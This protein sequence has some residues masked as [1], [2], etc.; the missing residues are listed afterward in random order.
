MLTF[1]SLILCLHYKKLSVRYRKR[2]TIS[3][4]DF[5][6][7]FVQFRF[8]SSF[9]P[10]VCTV[11]FFLFFSSRSI[12][13]PWTEIDYYVLEMI[14]MERSSF[15]LFLREES[16]EAKFIQ[17]ISQMTVKHTN[18]HRG[19]KRQINQGICDERDSITYTNHKW[20]Y[21]NRTKRKN[22][23]RRKRSTL[24]TCSFHSFSPLSFSCSVYLLLFV[25]F[26][27][28]ANHSIRTCSVLAINTSISIFE[29]ATK[30]F[31]FVLQ[32]INTYSHVLTDYLY[33]RSFVVLLTLPLR[34]S[35][36]K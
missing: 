28:I 25:Y 23:K 16:A 2:Y 12:V 26:I 33:I 29:G 22:R 17:N 34:T 27:H 36:A 3:P 7:N 15:I 18:K 5:H 11:V 31:S 35:L 19:K 13:F 8:T 32:L 24:L 20:L 4:F 9:I 21:Q 1:H 6:W 10:S 14:Y 30:E